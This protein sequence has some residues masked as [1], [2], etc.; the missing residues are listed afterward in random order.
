MNWLFFLT[1]FTSH[2]HYQHRLAIN[3]N[4]PDMSRQIRPTALAVLVRF[5]VVSFMFA[6]EAVGATD[7]S[8]HRPIVQ[9]PVFISVIFPVLELNQER[10]E[11]VDT[12]PD[13]YSFW[14][15]MIISMSTQKAYFP[16]PLSYPYRYTKRG[17]SALQQELKR[18][19][20]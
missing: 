14:G 20:E 12:I 13:A 5:I 1:E 8:I 9:G 6:S 18:K 19:S 2:T 16:A 11:M 3:R 10:L 17:L 15:R 4:S 7:A